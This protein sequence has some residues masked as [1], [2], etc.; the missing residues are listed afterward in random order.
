MMGNLRP[1]MPEG[2]GEKMPGIA[3]TIKRKSRLSQD[4]AKTFQLYHENKR[5]LKAIV[6]ML[7]IAVLQNGIAGGRR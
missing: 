6:A 4:R 7:R 2:N 3:P 5:A 1:A